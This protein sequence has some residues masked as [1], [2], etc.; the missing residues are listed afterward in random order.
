MAD[1][2]VATKTITIYKT[3]ELA[4]TALATAIHL[5]DT[6]QANLRCGI[7]RIEADRYAAWTIYT[8]VA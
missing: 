1:K 8:N 7:N 2:Y 4:A 5:I 6:G 3:V